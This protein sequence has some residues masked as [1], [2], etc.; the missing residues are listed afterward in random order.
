MKCM[1]LRS[2]SRSTDAKD[3]SEMKTSLNLLTAI[4]FI[5]NIMHCYFIHDQYIY[6]FH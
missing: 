6:L 4:Y 3:K 1:A 2:D 5:P